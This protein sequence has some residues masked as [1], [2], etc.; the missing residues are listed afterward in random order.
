MY[1]LHLKYSCY[2]VVKM[3]SPKGIQRFAG[4]RFK[5]GEGSLLG[6]GVMHKAKPATG[7]PLP[8]FYAPFLEDLSTPPASFSPKAPPPPES[9]RNDPKHHPVL[10][11][12]IFEREI[13]SPGTTSPR[14]E[15]PYGGGIS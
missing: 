2:L 9:I 5:F 14:L 6:D 4:D 3:R 12:N 11:Q 1:S 10:Y 13:L 8:D 15:F 7:S